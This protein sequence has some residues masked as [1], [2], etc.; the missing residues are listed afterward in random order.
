MFYWIR[1]SY[2]SGKTTIAK[3]IAV[4]ILVL[5]DKALIPL[6]ANDGAKSNVLVSILV[7]LDKALIP[8]CGEVPYFPLLEFQSLFYW[9]RLSYPQLEFFV[10]GTHPR[11]N[12]C[13]TG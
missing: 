12:P 5:L 2:G 1:L 9:I 6:C 8:D 11:F 3:M 10:I 4:S 7:L 13:S